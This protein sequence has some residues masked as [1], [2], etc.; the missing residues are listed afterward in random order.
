MT[1]YKIEMVSFNFLSEKTFAV[2][3]KQ[4]KMERQPHQLLT[5][6]FLLL[7][8]NSTKVAWTDFSDW[9][10]DYIMIITDMVIIKVII[11]RMPIKVV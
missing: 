4:G 5:F 10:K 1:Q 8:L 7:C 3:L 11:I 6:N 2:I 9:S